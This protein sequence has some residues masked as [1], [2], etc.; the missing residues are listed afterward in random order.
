[1][2]LGQNI[3]RLRTAKGMSQGALAE[4]LG[5]SRQSVSKWETDGSI[6]E[7]E[8]LINMAKLFEVSI[9]ELVTGEPFTPPE[10]PPAPPPAPQVAVVEKKREPRKTVGIVFLVLS[11]FCL[12]S[13]NVYLQILAA[14]PCLVVGVICL[15][16]GWHPGLCSLWAVGFMVD[17]YLRFGTGLSW[18]T[19]RWTPYWE[20]SMNYFR[21]FTAWAQLIG[22][23]LIILAS[24]LALRRETKFPKVP[25]LVTAG[26]LSALSLV[27]RWPLQYLLSSYILRFWSSPLEWAAMMGVAALAVKLLRRREGRA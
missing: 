10:A 14:A 15:L 20:P 1:M 26:V 27:L 11:I 7:L 5:V 4:A 2:T 8:K 12:L 6:P 13:G 19:V 9:D 3:T 18:R 16:V 22:M 24:I 23:A 17:T 21:L 25:L